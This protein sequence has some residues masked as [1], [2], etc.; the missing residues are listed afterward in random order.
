M[1]KHT[2]TDLKHRVDILA[3]DG[4]TPLVTGAWAGIQDLTGKRLEQ[5]QAVSSE[6][7]TQITMRANPLLVSSCFIQTDSVLYVVDYLLDPGEP[8]N[9][10][11]IEAYCHRVNDGIP[12]PTEYDIDG[13]TF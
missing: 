4:T 9:G 1:H 12:A 5:A 10:Y 6:V 7:T 13:G 2:T 11:W 8:R 3:G